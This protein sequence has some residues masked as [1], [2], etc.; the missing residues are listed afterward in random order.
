[1]RLMRYS[2]NATTNHAHHIWHTLWVPD[3]PMDDL[4]TTSTH[5]QLEPAHPSW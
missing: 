3:F 5:T 4:T 1:M 2:T